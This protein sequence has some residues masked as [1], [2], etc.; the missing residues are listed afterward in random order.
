[1]AVRATVVRRTRRNGHKYDV[2]VEGRVLTSSSTRAGADRVAGQY[3]DG[4]RK[5][6]C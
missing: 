6:P 2:V 4:K 3:R 5:V 1:M